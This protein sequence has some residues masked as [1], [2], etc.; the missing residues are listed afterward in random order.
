MGPNRS[1][2]IPPNENPVHAPT[3]IG[4]LRRQSKHQFASHDVT[5][6]RTEDTE[7]MSNSVSSVR[8]T[9]KTTGLAPTSC[10]PPPPRPLPPCQPLHLPR[11]RCSPLIRRSRSIVRRSPFLH[12][13][14]QPAD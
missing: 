4:Q 1:A 8:S 7:K 10:S 14:C 2:S 6:E 5:T 11:L 9:V 13:A 12:R 3:A